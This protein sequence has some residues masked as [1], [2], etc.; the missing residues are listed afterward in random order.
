M[1]RYEFVNTLK[2]AMHGLPQATIDEAV[3]DHERRFDDGIALGR[4]EEEIARELGDP[5]AI[6]AALRDPAAAASSA[7]AVAAED[8]R[9]VAR[10]ARVF[11]SSLGLLV[12]NGIMVVPALIYS[13][14]LLAFYMVAV[15][16]YFGGIA[17]TA[18]SLAGVNE[19]TFRMPGEHLT[20]D[21][22]HTRAAGGARLEQHGDRV[23][24]RIG[25]HGIH[26][27]DD[28]A[29][30]VIGGKGAPADPAVTVQ[31][32]RAALVVADRTELRS[33][34]VFHG[35]G[36]IL[37]GIV[38]LLLCAVVTRYTWIGMKRYVQMNIALLRTA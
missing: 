16:C 21:S 34:K 1:T 8:K 22:G 19:F 20:I 6:A 35:A 33:L 7:Q 5:F 15:A 2:A 17:L 4:A 27:A 32:D 9:G 13:F 28:G 18:S 3:A 29:G 11:V 24:V 38:L 12:F 10:A 26:V 36:I 37:G 14:L 30:V 25:D 31:H 23:R